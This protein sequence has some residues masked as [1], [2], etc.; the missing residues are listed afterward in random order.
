MRNVK[1]RAKGARMLHLK[2]R[3]NALATRKIRGGFSSRSHNPRSRESRGTFPTLKD[4]RLTSKHDL[5]VADASRVRSDRNLRR[6]AEF[7]R[8]TVNM[9]PRF[10]T[11]L[12]RMNGERP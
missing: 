3:D 11:L 4:Y 6:G 7:A 8:R 2:A 9:I 12:L 10:G 1:L 5:G